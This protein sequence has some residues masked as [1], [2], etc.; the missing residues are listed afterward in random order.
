[1]AQ[2]IA[3]PTL[4]GTLFARKLNRH[5]LTRETVL[6]LLLWFWFC[7]TMFRATQVPAFAGH[8]VTGMEQLKQVSKILLM[9]LLTILLVT[10]PKR[11][12][13]L[14]LLISL[15][16]GVRAMLG[17]IFVFQTGGEYRV[18]GPADSFVADNNAFALALNMVL[19]ML[20]FLAREEQNRWLHRVLYLAFGCSVICVILTYSRGGFVGLAVVLA[21]IAIKTRHKFLSVL[22]LLV[23]SL[24]V[25]SYAPEKWMTRMSGFLSGE[26]DSSAEQ[27]LIAWRTTWN[28]VQD[29]PI[30]GGGFDTSP[31]PQVFQRYAPKALPG[32]FASTGPHSIYFQMLGNHGFVGLGLF[33][34][35]LGSSWFTLRGLRKRAR[36]QRSEA[37]LVSYSHIMETSLLGYMAS[38]AF[39]GFAYFD[40][41]FQVI[42]CAIVLKI[43]YRRDFL[44]ATSVLVRPSESQV[45]ELAKA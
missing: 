36:G 42:A 30:T 10:S 9:T 14:L 8:L 28:F 44:A 33:L 4:L 3:V 11:L 2:V 25:F 45:T 32:G 19:P 39:L 7:F 23:V 26:V 21:A 43:L 15:S 40:L 17:A 31:D 5:F 12:R 35:L 24:A 6:L 38:G 22:M 34:L 16:F 37:W 27:R 18:Y 20:F 41:Y 13:Y 29:Y 1:V